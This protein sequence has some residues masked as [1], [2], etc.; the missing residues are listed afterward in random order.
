MCVSW[1]SRPFCP[2]N[3]PCATEA[4]TLDLGTSALVGEIRAMAMDLLR[5]TGMDRAE[6]SEALEE[7]VS[8]PNSENGL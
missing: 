4:E 2:G 7:G 8:N 3:D 5:V 1:P 6:I